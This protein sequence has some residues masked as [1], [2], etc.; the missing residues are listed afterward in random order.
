MSL[1]R[2]ARRYAVLALVRL[3]PPAWRQ[4]YAVEFAALLAEQ[5][6]SPREV[7]DVVRGA[8]DARRTAQHQCRG[9]LQGASQPADRVEASREEQRMARR[10]R[11][12]ACSF[13][14]KRQEQVQR[15][16][17]GPGGV[18]ICDECIR[19]C[20]EILAAERSTM[21]IQPVEPTQA[22]G[23]PRPMPRWQRL[24]R[25]GLPNGH[26]AYSPLRAHSLMPAGEL[27]TN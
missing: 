8:L 7:L 1:R 13:C 10:S 6:L 25:R 5:R 15:L 3:Y 4:R 26:H 22:A 14:G 17:A 20:N 19:L 2:V 23:H 21:P 12:L 18:H 16:I 9:R 11:D 24:L 27:P